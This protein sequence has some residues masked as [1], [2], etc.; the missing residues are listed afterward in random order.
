MTW[1]V[2][3]AA[4]LLKI[5]QSKIDKNNRLL[6]ERLTSEIKVTRK[7]VDSNKKNLCGAGFCNRA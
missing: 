1:V 2:M 4:S 6:Q 5:V 7:L 3:I